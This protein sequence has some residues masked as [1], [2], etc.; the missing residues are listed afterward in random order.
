MNLTEDQLRYA[1]RE[2]GAQIPADRIPPLQLDARATRSRRPVGRWLPAL[3]AAAAVLAVVAVVVLAGQPGPARPPASPLA[4]LPQYYVDLQQQ[5]GC[6]CNLNPPDSWRVDPD[7]A[8]VRTRSGQTLAIVTVPKPYGT[9]VAVRAAADDRTF[10]LAAQVPEFISDGYPATR[11]Y[12]LRINPAAPAGHKAVLAALPVPVVP[13]GFV[14]SGVALS[15]DGTRLAVLT[16][17]N[18]GTCPA[19]RLVIYDLATGTSR[20]WSVAGGSRAPDPDSGAMLWA[21]DNRTLAINIYDQGNALALLDTAAPDRS[22]QADARIIHLQ[23]AI[24]PG[25]AHPRSVVGSGVLTPDGQHVLEYLVNVALADRNPTAPAAE[26]L[27]Q[28]TLATGAA[29]VL[30]RDTG[31]IDLAWTDPSGS[32]VLVAR[33]APYTG[34]LNRT[35][36]LLYAGGSARITLPPETLAMAW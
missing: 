10:L 8:L 28:L 36:T 14:P 19:S 26:S 21:A 35:A 32:A 33:P 25:Q 18:V 27:R 34:I 30:F 11:F 22:F 15:P 7:R 2:T 6:D 12:L 31:S 20:T 9:F 29:R 24:R 13:A 23:R 3:G 17:P 1:L 5:P 4:Q 16:C